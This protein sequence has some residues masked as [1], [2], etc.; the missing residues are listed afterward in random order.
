VKQ[1]GITPVQNVTFDIALL[2]TTVWITSWGGG[3]R[4]S[5]DMG[6]TW[7]VVTP[8][9]F[10][11]DPLGNLN[12]RPFSVIAVEDTL[13]VGTAQGINKSIDDGQTWENFSHQNQEHSIS[14]NF[15]VALAHQYGDGKSILWAAT[16]EAEDPEESRA[17]SKTEDGGRTWST[18]LEGEFA[19]NFGIDRVA[20][21]VYVTTDN[22]LFK[23]VDGDSFLVFPQIVDD[24]KGEKVYTTE[25]YSAA[26]ADDGYLWAGSGDGVA[27]TNN[28]GFT[29]TI[30]RAFEPT[31]QGSTPRTYAYPNPFSPLRHNQIGGDGNVRF[32]YN[33]KSA[34]R[35]TVRVYDFALYLVATIVESKSRPAGDFAEVWE[36]HNAIGDMVANGVYFY[37]VEIEGDGV[38][39]G[40]VMVLN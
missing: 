37:S 8:D 24:V 25:F 38:Y 12:H 20:G 13:W 11:F 35:V 29:W 7:E 26:V 1:P 21:T 16:I 33:T 23:S 19:H 18:V 40:K 32:Q 10:L 2:D 14:G 28:N 17:V 30:Y 6:Q 9:T 34:T 5:S 3:L 39:W 27:K 36:G 31:G 4:K 15:V 22:G